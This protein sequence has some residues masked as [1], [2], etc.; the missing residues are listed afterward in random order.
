MSLTTSANHYVGIGEYLISNN[1]ANS[2]KTFALSSCVAVLAYHPLKLIAGMIHIALP[3]PTQG[4]FL[5]D[6]PGYFASTGVPL[7]LKEICAKY[8][9]LPGELTIRIYGGAKSVRKNDFFHIGERNIKAVKEA[10]AE[11]NLGIQKE[12]VGGFVSRTLE[13][14][15]NTGFVKVTEQPL[16]I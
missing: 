11:F 16:M 4:T 3:S 13:M 9:C 2:I 5:K 14:S 1:S 15:V 12:V 7:M 8:G 6:R 10:L